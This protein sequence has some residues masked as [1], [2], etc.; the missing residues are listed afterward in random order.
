MKAAVSEET[1]N[2]G[3]RLTCNAQPTVKIKR[4]RIACNARPWAAVTVVTLNPY[5]VTL[6]AAVTEVRLDP[7]RRIACN[8]QPKTVTLR[9]AVSEE[10]LN[11]E[12][13]VTEVTHN[14][15]W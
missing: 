13:A 4:W 7:G 1:N 3:R 15:T 8:A 11:P 6:R 9:A 10:M 12:G 5:L 2:P 14:P